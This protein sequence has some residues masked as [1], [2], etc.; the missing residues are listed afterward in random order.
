MFDADV[1]DDDGSGG[2]AAAGGGDDDL[3]DVVGFV[4]VTVGDGDVGFGVVDFDNNS[5]SFESCDAVLAIFE[6]NSF[7]L[8]FLNFLS[9]VVLV[10]FVIA[11]FDTDVVLT[12][13]VVGVLV[14]WKFPLCAIFVCGNCSSVFL[15]SL[16][17]FLCSKGSVVGLVY[18]RGGSL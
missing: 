13:F 17:A 3:V 2:S 1:D 12:S 11:F 8:D 9:I 5:R 14:T 10:S 18:R 6:F 7:V 16:F 4:D 15:S